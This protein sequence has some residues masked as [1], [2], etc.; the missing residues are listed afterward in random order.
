MSARRPAFRLRALLLAVVVLSP[1]MVLTGCFSSPPQIVQ[2]NPPA[3]STQL[4]ADATVEVVF[5]QPVTH[6]SVAANL[7]VSQTVRTTLG[8]TGCDLTAAFTARPGAPCWV[9]WLT[10]EPGFVLHHPG[11]LFA[12]D[13]EYAFTL[14]AG[15]TS[16][17]G[18]VNSLD[19]VWDLTSAAAPVLNSTAPGNGAAVPQDTP[20]VLSFSRAMSTS[21]VA[22]AV[23]LSP[24]VAGLQVVRNT[25][26]LG[27]FE[28]IPR[29][30]LEPATTYT[31]TVSRRATDAFGE[32]LAAPV[33]IS[34]HTTALSTA[35]HLLVLA[36]PGVGDATEVV[37]AQLSAP[38]SGLPVPAQI[39]Y[40]APTCTD[41][42]GCGEVGT[43][44]PTA[45]IEAAAMA[46][47]GRWLAVVQ[48]DVTRLGA[49]PVLRI[50]DVETGED[51]L[52]LTG[53]TWPAWSPDG[54][55][56][57]FVAAGSSVQLWKPASETLSAL[58]SGPAP[59]GR[60]IWTADGDA[61]AIPVAATA[62]S[63]A[64]VDLAVPAINARYKLPGITG[65]AGSLVAA[66]QGEELALEVTAPGTSTPVTWVVDPAS[67]SS[68]TR[69]GAGLLPVGFTDDATLVVA[70][71]AA[72][73]SPQLGAYDIATGELSTIATPVGSV[74]P[75]SA[76]V[77]PGGRQVAYITRTAAGVDDAV[78]ANA[79]GSGPL[80][81][82]SLATGLQALSVAFGG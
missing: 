63:P 47:G 36:G 38:A 26:D 82:S 41:P 22:G 32:P 62:T 51:Q 46:P 67:G 79:D 31:L 49:P 34:F 54:S 50:I 70:L 15:V 43:G 77:A 5:D 30:P 53:A 16:V 48:T 69:V 21:A 58:P 66:P 37:L 33:S 18:Q 72:P 57:A 19:H 40:S 4:D 39:L 80:L 60:P 28:V 56:L 44:Q 35:G 76:T 74:D 2:L 73:G 24:A 68:A 10:G 14:A 45:T 25:L 52:D 3:G 8:L 20:I 55:T 1:S 61:L 64:H 81:V 65:D 13:T 17:N 12:P 42:E 29:S 75:L 6:R 23:S 9:S 11:A 59:N 27:Q 71:A 7:R 78:I